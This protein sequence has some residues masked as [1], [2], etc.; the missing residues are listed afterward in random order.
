MTGRHRLRLRRPLGKLWLAA[1]AIACAPGDARERSGAT[2]ILVGDVVTRDAP[3]ERAE[4]IAVGS[5][6]VLA[7]GTRAEVMA[8]RTRR[9]VVLEVPQ[10]TI[11]PAFRDHHVHLLNVGYGLL[12]IVRGEA[13]YLDV[14]GASL[15]EV[16]QRVAGRAARVPR[17]TWIVGR[18]WNQAAFGG[19]VLPTHEILSRAAPE[20]PVYLVRVDA[21]A[22]WANA[23]ALDLAGIRRETPDPPGGRILRT[24][25]GDPTGIL[26]ERAN[27]LLLAVLP[28]RPDSEIEA[29]FRLAAGALAARGVT[30]VFDAGFLSFPGVV[31]LN[32]PFRRYLEILAA[33]DRREGL[34]ITVNVMLPAPSGFADSVRAWSPERRRL[35][36][37]VRVTHIKLF[38]DG[39]LGSRGA[40]LG[41]PYADDRSTTGVWRMDAAALEREVVASLAAGMDVA[42]HAIGDAAGAMVLD[43]YQRM[44]ARDPELDPR[45]LRIEHFTAARPE[46]LVRASRLGVVL[47]VQ[48][49]FIAPDFRGRTLEDARLGS[50]G[51][52]SA[53][54]YAT[55]SALGA[56]LVGSSDAYAD[57][58]QP[59]HVVY[60]AEARRGPG[61]GGGPPWHPNERLRRAA[62]LA[63]VFDGATPARLAVGEP[64]DLVV[65]TDNP[66]AV[67]VERLLQLTVLYTVRGGRIVYRAADGLGG[68]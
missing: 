68:T 39:A 64:A 53:H 2:L 9:T 8:H 27:E 24:E 58:P 51:A 47:V 20:H 17:G 36:P 14:S 35:S 48:P 62:A 4:A 59:L 50:S 61:A 40:A 12:R 67:P 38:A 57:V 65:L 5:A 23:R 10:A 7:V 11:L 3:R 56:R 6:G 1:V 63:L 42:T 16:A 37:R 29:A 34:P 18:G 25:R 49:G 30:E 41:R 31:G 45:R 60:A 21:H 15:A 44:L 13:L 55:L 28:A 43:V 54:A 46:D 19:G 22:G 26:L 32:A 33:L 52:V 66:Y